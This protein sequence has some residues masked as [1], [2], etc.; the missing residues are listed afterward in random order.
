MNDDS[1]KYKFRT[2][3]R[4][5][6]E[7]GVVVYSG[8]CFKDVNDIKFETR[9]HVKMLKVTDPV[10]KQLWDH[11]HSIKRGSKINR[12]FSVYVYKKEELIGSINFSEILDNPHGFGKD[13]FHITKRI[14]PEFQGTKYSRYA[15]GN[16]IHILFLSNI[17]N[18]IYCYLPA[19]VGTVRKNFLD[20]LDTTTPC[21]GSIGPQDG[22]YIGRYVH[23]EKK[24]RTKWGDYI[25]LRHDGH[26]YRSMDLIKYYMGLTGKTKETVSEW[27]SR[28]E[29]MIVSLNP[30]KDRLV[31]HIDVILRS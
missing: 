22:L 11:R 29:K 27:M 18:N 17:A 5:L 9:Q 13:D 16:L 15:A 26:I 1:W 21:I 24:F 20:E 28:M 7:T 31:Q 30:P 19:K 6:P 4:L 14:F 25:L 8:I 23:I 10:Q 12:R 2:Y 3:N